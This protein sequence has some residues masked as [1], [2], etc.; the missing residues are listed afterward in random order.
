MI[1]N[2]FI[3]PYPDLSSAIVGILLWNIIPNERPDDIVYH[4][5]PVPMVDPGQLEMGRLDKQA[6]IRDGSG[7][8]DEEYDDFKSHEPAT[9]R[10][11]P[12]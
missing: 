10:I 8:G 3:Q 7:G 6:S 9:S 4:E 5:T 11:E 12:V 2:A 1:L